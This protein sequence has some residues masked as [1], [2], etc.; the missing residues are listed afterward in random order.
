MSDSKLEV[1]G[2]VHHFILTDGTE[3]RLSHSI[4]ARFIWRVE[5][6]KTYVLLDEQEVPEC[7][8]QEFVWNV[9]AV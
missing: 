1:A 8:Q 4:D 3:Y 6:D 2:L 7:L 5:D 9:P